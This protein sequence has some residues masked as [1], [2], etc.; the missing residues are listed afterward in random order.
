VAKPQTTHTLD[1]SDE[2]YAIATSWILANRDTLAALSP[3]ARVMAALGLLICDDDG[4]IAEAHLLSAMSDPRALS[5][6]TLLVNGAV[7]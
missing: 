3:N 5:A 7:N 6:A 4:H 1:L 2:R